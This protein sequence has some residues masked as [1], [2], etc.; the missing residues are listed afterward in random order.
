M[1]NFDYLNKIV[2]I[3]IVY[4]G[5]GLSGKTTNLSHIHM[6]LDPSSPEIES[7]LR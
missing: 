1:P 3:N 6:K 2:T 4:C 5:P 7:R